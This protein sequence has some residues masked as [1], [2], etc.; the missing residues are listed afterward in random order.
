M[1]IGKKSKVY[2]LEQEIKLHIPVAA[3]KS[4]HAQ[5]AALPGPRRTHLR[6][7]YFDTPQRMLAR[8]HAALRIRLEGRKWVQ[9]FKMAGADPLSRIELNHTAAG[10]TLDLS[11][12]EGSPA[13]EILA[14]LDGE[15]AVRYETDVL[16][17]TRMI[18][19]RHGQVELAHD[20]GRIQ[21][22]Q[23]AV[24]V[25]ELEFERM[26]GSTR[27][28]FD[29]ARRWLARHG[30]VLDARS[31]AERGDR[32]AEAN[33]CLNDEQDADPAPAFQLAAACYWAPRQADAFTWTRRDEPARA[34]ARIAS[35]CYDQIVRNAAMLAEVDTGIDQPPQS[36]PEHLHQL[37]VGIR[38]LR[39]AWR[40]FEGWPVPPS[41]ALQDAAE[42]HFRSF[43]AARDHDVLRDSIAPRLEAAG[44]PSVTLR[45]A[46]DSFNAR[47]AARSRD[48]QVWQLDLLE[49][50]VALANPAA[51]CQATTGDEPGSPDVASVDIVGRARKTLRALH[52]HIVHDGIRIE[53]M[54]DD[55][56]HTLRKRVKRLRYG[57][58]FTAGLFRR[59][60][61][62]RYLKQLAVIQ[63][64]L[65]EINDLVVAREGY[66][67]LTES[68]PS[69]WF[70]VGWICARLETPAARAHR[71]F[72]QLASL[73]P[74]WK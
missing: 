27:A 71:A 62:K 12:Y 3:R 8:K 36:G 46:D 69:A 53:A 70:A 33:A 43:S 39:S 60:P 61:M 28:V 35:N 37:R 29:L 16:R 49:W 14:E 19:T 44:M 47:D 68:T 1:S 20:T 2:M 5:L 45:P 66:Q 65:G 57:L 38:R 59:G 10:P 73:P 74:F 51:P 11:V 21:S 13:G 34:L 41:T 17:L 50:A 56:R 58:A 54:N 4:V 40:L 31:K 9:T 72:K 63:D 64:E 26:S 24:P 7:L 18:R 6:A 22:G 67:A 52:K 23:L 42:V 55:A 15:L 25:D 48:F 30:L 32:L